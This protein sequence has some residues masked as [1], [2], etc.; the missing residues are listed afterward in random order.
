MYVERDDGERIHCRHPLEDDDILG[1]LRFSFREIGLNVWNVS[2]LGEN[3]KWWW[4]ATR[5]IDLCA[6]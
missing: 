5:G 2:E 1:V 6:T 3:A 4:S